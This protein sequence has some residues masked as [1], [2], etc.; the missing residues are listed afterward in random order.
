MKRIS[1][2]SVFLF[3]ITVSSFC[4]QFKKPTEGKA[5]VY[6]AR[7]QGALALIDFK[8]FDGQKYLGKV[9]GDNYYIYTC[10]PGEH[11]FW[12]AAPENQAFIKG[13]LKPDCTYVIE[14]RPYLRAVM[15]GVKLIQISPTDN[16][17][18]KKISKLIQKIEPAE[19]KGQEE[20][21]DLFIEKGMTR[22][23]KIENKVLELNPDWTF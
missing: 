8:Y 5:Q 4:Q 3:F 20:D 14:V 7:F 6:F 15:A 21:L 16:R 12:V 18:L 11:V 2:L 23:G 9:G 10:E 1:V 17:A 22:Y 19:L 13:D